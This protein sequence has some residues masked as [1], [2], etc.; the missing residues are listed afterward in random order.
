MTTLKNLGR[1]VSQLPLLLV[2]LVLLQNLY[3]PTANAEPDY[4]YFADVSASE[5]HELLT[6]FVS[7]YALKKAELQGDE[8][9]L[10]QQI[11]LWIEQTGIELYELE[12]NGDVAEH[13]R[14]RALLIALSGVKKEHHR[15]S[16]ISNNALEL[17]LSNRLY[18]DYSRNGYAPIRTEEYCVHALSGSIRACQNKA[19]RASTRDHVL[20]NPPA[21]RFSF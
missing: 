3:L 10:Y 5:S 16:H 18:A 4:G 9:L 11:N 17:K 15:L 14:L 12:T 7:F 8:E 19:I 20:T 21:Q 13:S 2:A 1:T 6:R